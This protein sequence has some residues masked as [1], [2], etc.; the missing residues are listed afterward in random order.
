MKELTT[1]IVLEQMTAVAHHLTESDHPQLQKL[2]DMVNDWKIWV[3]SVE[4]DLDE[5]QKIISEQE[6]GVE[7]EIYCPFEKTLANAL[8][9]AAAI[10][11]PTPEE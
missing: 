10:I 8:K 5:A 2:G 6:E 11:V 4:D 3:D 9:D 7:G 1:N